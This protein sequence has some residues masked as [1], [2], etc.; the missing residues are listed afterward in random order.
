[1]SMMF[2]FL[3]FFISTL[4]CVQFISVML[5][6]LPSVWEKAANSADHLEFCCLLRYVFPFD[7]WDGLWVLIWPVPEVSLLL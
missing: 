1:M 7:D 2:N 3:F 5:T 4:L 6:E